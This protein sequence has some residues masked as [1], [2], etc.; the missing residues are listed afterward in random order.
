MY[1]HLIKIQPNRKPFLFIEECKIIE[2]GKT[3]ES[4]R[5]FKEDEYFL[6]LLDFF[7]KFKNETN[8]CV[9]NYLITYLTTY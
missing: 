1:Q 7:R 2:K 3:G 5:T 4:F 8:H 6:T 9:D